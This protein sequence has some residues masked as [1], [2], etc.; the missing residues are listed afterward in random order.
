M[1]PQ[2]RWDSGINGFTGVRSHSLVAKRRMVGPQRI[3]WQI[4]A[5]FALAFHF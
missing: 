2:S 5:L 1:F 3:T 4:F